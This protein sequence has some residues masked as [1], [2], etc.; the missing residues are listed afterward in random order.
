M[1]YLYR[2]RIFFEDIKSKDRIIGLTINFLLEVR[3]VKTLG[4]VRRQ[5]VKDLQNEM[6]QAKFRESEEQEL[7]A[8]DF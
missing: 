4:L 6:I 3:D 8:K 7:L 5:L 2:K 1:K